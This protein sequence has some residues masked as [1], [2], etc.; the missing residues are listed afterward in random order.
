MTVQTILITGAS[1][2]IGQAL[3]LRYAAAGVRV[4][5]IGQRVFPSSLAGS[6]AP[7][8]YAAIDLGADDC[9]A[10]VRAFL[11]LRQ[12]THLDILVHN[13]ACGWYG[14]PVQ[15]DNAS[16]DRL[17][18]VNLYAPIAL[19]HALLPRLRLADGVVAFV[20]SVHSV[21]PTPDFAVYTATKAGLDGFARSL[22]LEERRAVDVI[23]L[24]PGPTRTQMHTRSG[25]PAARIRPERFASPD[26]VAQAMM[27]AIQR[28]RSRAVGL[29]NRLLRWVA[30]RF[31]TP[32][33][34]L[35]AM[36]ARRRTPPKMG[37]T[38]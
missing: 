13:A 18:D 20:S 29:G 14:V 27:N 2:G 21:L 36:L 7:T 35:L 10:A 32:L 6:V 5:G 28:R 25:V 19:T 22:R 24:W 23:V 33:D 8:D 16:I 37:V 15:Q 38:A 9:V 4:L 12:V 34:A 3:A 31:D 17:L 11:D 1:D 30:L 26:T